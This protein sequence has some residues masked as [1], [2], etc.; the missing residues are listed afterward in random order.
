M[1]K[2]GFI[3]VAVATLETKVGDCFHNTNQIIKL[4][5][6]AMNDQINMIVYPELCI[7]GYTCGDLFMQNYLQ[8]SA[9][10]SLIEIKHYSK[11]KNLGM[12]VGV[13]IKVGSSLFNCG[14][15]IYDGKILGLVPKQFM[16]TYNEFYEHR[17]FASA[18]VLSQ[19]T[20]MIDGDK[21]PIGTDLI[22]SNA[23]YPDLKIG[24]EICED[25]WTPIPPS[26]ILALKG[27]TLIANLSASNELVG[28]IDY[29]KQLLSDQSARCICGY[30]YASSGYGESTTDVVYGGHCLIYENGTLLSENNRFQLNAHYTYS[31]ID[32]N[33]INNDRV[34]MTTFRDSTLN[35]KHLS[36]R[37]ITF[38]QETSTTALSRIIDPH[39]FVPSNT[40]ER[41]I[42]CEEI[43][44]IQTMGLTKRLSHIGCNKV[45]LGISGGLDS[46]LALLV[47]SKTF[48]NLGLDKKNI[49]GVTMPG[50]GT[51]DRTY[52]NALQL[53]KEMGAT[54]KEIP[55]KDACEI[56]FKDIEH[57]AS[58]H[59]VT[60]ENVQARERTQILMD[61]SNKENG[62][63]IGTGDLSELA[64]GWA[65]YNG[66]H[67][68]MYGVNVSIPKTL[69]RYL[70]E[71]VS[72]HISNQALQHTLKDILSTPVSPE[73]LPPDPDGDI[74]QKTEEVVGPYELHD[75]FLYYMVRFGFT[76]SKI[77]LLAEKAFKDTYSKETILS[78]LKV[79]YRRFFTQQFKRSCLPDGPKVGS[80]CLSPRGDWR[81]PSDAAVAG[82]LADLENI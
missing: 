47:C 39:P 55:I 46:T 13:P 32:I 51:T 57:D 82:W 36:Y 30:L 56:H 42:R 24:I 9:L 12:F 31:E 18:N 2:Y 15:F 26:T 8:A 58:I 62:I 64:L 80:I 61:L 20:I 1:S 69:V 11:D 4:A 78:W 38:E 41:H 7:T 76:P 22:F 35:V 27:A 72:D 67:M 81:M 53:V 10:K 3:K 34:K 40:T 44:S 74:A 37:E 29:R 50:Y 5:S 6:D 52:Q 16:P 14:A 66:D 17:W 49:I 45:V 43:F 19:D 65:T 77:L 63:V 25:L 68:S 21:V 48:E 28:K 79:F 54:L 23:M 59:D 70:V 73:L 75:F 60:F 71:W 33:R